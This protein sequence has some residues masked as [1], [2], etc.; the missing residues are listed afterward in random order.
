MFCF[1]KY[2]VRWC[3]CVAYSGRSLGKIEKIGLTPLEGNLKCAILLTILS[4]TQVSLRG[5]KPKG[6]IYL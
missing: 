2:G 1:V 5:I 6:L 4:D 3:F